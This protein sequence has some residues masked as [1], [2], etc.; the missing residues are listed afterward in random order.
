MSSASSNIENAKSLAALLPREA[1]TAAVNVQDPA[2]LD[3]LVE[4]HD[5]VISLIPYIYHADVI[6]S[7]IK[8]KKNVVTTSYVSDAMKALEPEVKKA[9]IVVMNEIGLDPGIDHLYA[10]KTIDDTH[11]AGGKVSNIL[12][13]QTRMMLT[14]LFTRSTLSSHTV[15]VFPLLAQLATLSATSSA[16]L[17]EVFFLL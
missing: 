17:R 5:L 14:V 8:F 12:S 15:V 10:V 7:A 1:Q 9:G 2:S 11:K 16:G 13:A 6:K 4:Q 3:A